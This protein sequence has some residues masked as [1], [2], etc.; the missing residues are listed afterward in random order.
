MTI[1]YFFI[2]F[3]SFLGISKLG[4]AS[5][6]SGL[7]HED[8]ISSVLLGLIVFFL[9]AKLGGFLAQK[10]KQPLVL[11]ELLAGILIGNL[12]IF[13]IHSFEFLRTESVYSIMAS[14]GVILLLF[15]VGLESSLKDL[16]KV[17]KTAFIVAVIG[18]VVPSFLGFGVS[19][20]LFPEF[21]FYTHL[22]IGTTLCATSVGITA[23]VLKDLKKT[24]T[25]EAK[26]ILGAAVIDDVL[27]LILLA[28]V[29]GLIMSAGTEGAGGISFIG[30]AWIS[31]KAIGFLLVTLLV[32]TL[33]APT[34]FKAVARL[35]IDGSLFG[36]SLIVCFALAYLSNFVGLAPIVGSFAAGLMMDSSGLSKF[37]G[38][39]EKSIEEWIL[40]L[41]KF[42]VPI[43]F[44]HMGLQ[45]QYE[46]FTNPSVLILGLTLAFVGILGKQACSLGVFGKKM[47]RLAIGIGMVPR[48]EVG[49]I[50]AVMGTKL[51][52][53]GRPVISPEIYSAIIIMVLLTTMF[54]PPA[55]KWSLEKS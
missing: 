19:Q 47:N 16:L 49:L 55:L 30:I 20:F 33:Y 44:V 9:A 4:F 1:R 52:F 6:D 10:F 41:S 2:C 28:V 26:I 23:R 48:G 5:S 13:G 51:V 22:F 54:T 46:T 25:K 7:V 27:G 21:S 53:E 14:L 32:G 50:F 18:V 36:F 3:L 29:S 17:G 38:K 31:V 15:E 43:F 8:P 12:S 42:F 39:D 24:H 45:V 11:G 37:F 40:P 35:K 34:L